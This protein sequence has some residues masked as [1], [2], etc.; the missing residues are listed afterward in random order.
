MHNSGEKQLTHTR[1]LRFKNALGPRSETDQESRLSLIPLTAKDRINSRLKEFTPNWPY[2]KDY[3]CYMVKNKCSCTKILVVDDD[4]YNLL[5]IQQ[6][7]KALSFASDT[8]TNG[9]VAIQTIEKKLAGKPCGAGCLRGY[10]IIFMDCNMN[11]MN[12]Y[13]ATQIIKSRIQE[14]AFPEMSV[15]ATTAYVLR[16]CIQQVF[17]SGMDDFIAKPLCTDQIKEMIQKYLLN[18]VES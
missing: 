5:A 16:E 12:G 9:Q 17:E 13:K 4:G 8:A 10:P 6:L 15:I 2:D 14:K 18:K 11:V 1:R 3:E 7:L